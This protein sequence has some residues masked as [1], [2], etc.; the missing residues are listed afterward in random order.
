MKY[1]ILMSEDPGWDELSTEEQ[2]AI[3]KEHN[4][5]EA[6]LNKQGSLV[7]SGRF[8]SSA[9]KSVEQDRTGEQSIQL[10]PASGE[11]AVG[12]YYL[13]EVESMDEALKWAARCRFITGTNW[14]YP[15]WD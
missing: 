7:S 4:Q 3:I 8:D 13:I 9:G 14:V 5:F 6:D 11:G 15:L 1:M 2:D 10:C 12:G